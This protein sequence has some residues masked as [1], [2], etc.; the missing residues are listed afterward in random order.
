MPKYEIDVPGQG[1][2][3]VDSPTELTDAQ[4]Y[5]AVQ[6]QLKPSAPQKAPE[7]IGFFEAIPAAAK[8]GVESLGDVAKGLGIAGKRCASAS[9]IA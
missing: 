9:I 6:A 8:R 2:F 7:E 5:A 4:A 3:E 1:K